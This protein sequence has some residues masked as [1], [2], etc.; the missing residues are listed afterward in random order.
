VQPHFEPS[1]YQVDTDLASRGWAPAY[2]IRAAG[3][4]CGKKTLQPILLRHGLQPFDDQEL[5]FCRFLPKVLQ[6]AILWRLVPRLGL[7]YA[8]ELEDG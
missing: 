3:A 7:S 1:R 2:P 5:R 8:I 6:R 4:R